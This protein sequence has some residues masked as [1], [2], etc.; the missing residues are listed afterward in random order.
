MPAQRG[1]QVSTKPSV[2]FV[3][4]SAPMVRALLGTGPAEAGGSQLQ[5]ALLARELRKRGWAVSFV[6]GDFGQGQRVVADGDIELIACY[7][8]TRVPKGLRLPLHRVPR[9]W[10][11]VSKAGADAYVCQ[12]V[13]WEAGLV[14]AFCRVRGAKCVIRMGSAADPFFADGEVSFIPRKDRLLSAYGLRHAHAVTAQTQ[15]Q[16]TMLHTRLGRQGVL[17]PNVWSVPDE[18]QAHNGEPRALW[19]GRIEG[20]KR[21]QMLL[22]VAQRLQDISFVMAGGRGRLR[23]DR[24]DAVQTRA[25]Q[26]PNVVFRG[27]V[28]PS[29]LDA[30]YAAASVLVSTSEIEGFPNTFL[31]AWGHARPVVST[32]DPDQ[33]LCRERVGFHCQS[34][35]DVAGAVERLCRDRAEAA[36]MGARGR[37]YVQTHHSPEVVIPRLERILYDALQAKRPRRKPL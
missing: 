29:D 28:P 7:G 17:L 37:A 3:A 31:Q 24:F 10:R 18:V 8:N 4:P 19:V 16:L 22:D 21:P 34:V 30:E 5:L 13:G 23:G 25:R 14:A 1:S 32:Y 9:M 33:V 35:E 6:V 2:C 11:A 27:F 20:V 12:G 15:E 36:A 26:I